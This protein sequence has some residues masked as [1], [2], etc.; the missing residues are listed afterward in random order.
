[1]LAAYGVAA[2]L[3]LPVA[4]A[5]AALHPRTRTHLSE[6]LALT[7]PPVQPGAL[8]LHA[9][10]L[11]EGQ[12]AA[13]VAEGLSARWPDLPLLRTATSD[14]GRQ[15]V[16]PV[17]A[18]GCLPLDAPWLQRRFVR[19]VRPRA[20]V[21][22]EGE[23]WPGLLGACRGSVPVAVLG[24]RVGEG[25]R[26]LAARFPGL[27]K[28]MLGCVDSWSVRDADD[29]AWL[30]PWLD[31]EVPVIGDLKLQAPTAPATL[32]FERPMVLAG[33]TRPGDEAALLAAR[34]QLP[35]PPLL[36]LAPRHAERF[37]AV[38][39][40]LQNSDV[41]WA[42]SSEL[43]QALV[44]ANVDVLLLDNVGQ[45][46]SLY[47]LAVAAFVGGTF[48]PTIGGH[49]AAEANRAGVCVVHG[50]E[51]HANAASFAQACS[52][53]AATHRGLAPALAAALAS[54]QPVPIRGDAVGL[55]LGQLSSLVA[56][57]VPTE[58]SLRPLLRPLAPV[59]RFAASLRARRARG[60]ADIPVISVGNIA[61]GGTGKTQ[62]VRH[63]LE[64]LELRGLRVAVISRGYR[65]AAEGPWLRDSAWEQ[66]NS[67]WLG[68][69]LA[70]LSRPGVLAVSCPDRFAGARRAAE[71]G[72]Q[73]CLLDDGFQQR[74][75]AVDLDLVT[76]D[77]LR[78]LAGGSLPAGELREVP[79]ALGRADAVWILHGPPPA[80]ITSQLASTPSVQ[81]E[82]RVLGWLHGGER[83]PLEGGPDG[84][85]AVLAGIAKPAVFLR[86]LRRL[87]L[88]PAQRLI[89]RDHP[90]F[91]DGDLALFRRT[92]T[93]L[94]LV[95][96]EKDLARLPDD[97][98]CWALR[99]GL[100]I[101]QGGDEFHALLD[102][103]LVE[104]GL[105]EASE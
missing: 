48:D 72:A 46:A 29:A 78:P 27:W 104:R 88:V 65:R 93:E 97:L 52:F 50:P 85:V 91:S 76:I 39:T 20:L 49:S 47:P 37:E 2:Q 57:S 80:E 11:G 99:V 74:D 87:G 84:R 102:R 17:D 26:R 67:E 89:Y 8:W 43:G 1:M 101:Q 70:M 66:G 38:A 9:A 30:A 5:W 22:V 51:T 105:T 34:D 25:T 21:L 58:H 45:L 71:L 103:F 95:T 24:L 55:A 4:A 16:L 82:V 28:A 23:L 33:S 56:G 7:I 63:L 62:L 10:S 68:D 6:R 83:I 35:D 73:I 18:V 98:P 61:S 32:S 12:A 64:Q 13:A 19:R 94:P 53:H 31:A 86:Q 59:Y 40:L 44:P 42:R 75:L 100:E 3:A 90:W 36:V 54:P 14:T 41:R 79:A 92:A 69:E 15:Q 60:V 96:T 77:A 81:A